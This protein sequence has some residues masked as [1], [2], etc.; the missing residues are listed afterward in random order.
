VSK[1]NDFLSRLSEQVTMLGGL[2]KTARQMAEGLQVVHNSILSAL[3]SFKEECGIVDTVAT[4]ITAVVPK[5]AGRCQ[6]IRPNGEQCK[7]KVKHDGEFCKYHTSK[8]VIS[9]VG[10]DG[11]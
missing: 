6:A 11:E 7:L 3:T 2:A 1:I 8:D 9:L 5:E 10:G 4:P